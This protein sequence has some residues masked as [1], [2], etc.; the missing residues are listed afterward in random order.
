MKQLVG[1]TVK[2]C[3]WAG[4]LLWVCTSD[5][6]SVHFFD[7]T[8]ELDGKAVEPGESIN[9]VLA[10]DCI[11]RVAADDGWF[12]VHF[13]SASIL[14]VSSSGVETAR[15]FKKGD[16]CS[17]FVYQNGKFVEDPD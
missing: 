6:Y 9:E 5:G 1:K 2:E 13:E 14:R 16:L 4:P 7:S 3:G 11:A 12:S 8:I 15:A 10:G 17:H